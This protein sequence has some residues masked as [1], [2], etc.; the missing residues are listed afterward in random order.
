[1]KQKDFEQFIN[2][3]DPGIRF[4][5]LCNT[6]KKDFPEVKSQI[7]FDKIINAFMFI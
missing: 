1:M 5:R 2:N 6:I 4:I 7:I 3:T